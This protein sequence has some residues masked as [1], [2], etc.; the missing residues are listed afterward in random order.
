MKKK[1]LLRVFSFL[2]AGALFLETPAQAFAARMP[3]TIE[4]AAEEDSAAQTEDNDEETPE[5]PESPTEGETPADSETP[6]TPEEPENPTDPEKPETPEEPENPTDPEKP[7]TPEEPE[8]PTDPEKP[9]EPENPTDPEKPETPEEPENPTDPEKP[10]TPEEPENPTDPEKPED[11]TNPTDPENPENPADIEIPDPGVLTEETE[12]P[13]LGEATTAK[14]PLTIE[15]AIYGTEPQNILSDA[16]AEGYKEVLNALSGVMGKDDL[17]AVDLSAY[18]IN[19]TQLQRLLNYL[20]KKNG[21]SLTGLLPEVTYQTDDNGYVHNVWFT[22]AETSISIQV[23]SRSDTSI[24]LRL[25]GLVPN[26]DK[27]TLLRRSESETGVKPVSS[28]QSNTLF[29]DQGTK[30]IHD[31]TDILYAYRGGRICAYTNLVTSEFALAV[32]GGLTVTLDN[33]ASATLKWT[34]PNGVQNYTIYR[35]GASVATLGGDASGWND[36][37]VSSGKNHTY[38]VAAYTSVGSRTCQS[39]ASVTLKWDNGLSKPSVSA[40]SSA[41]DRVTLS[42]GGVSKAAGYLIYQKSGSSFKNL[43]DTSATSYTITGLNA[44]S[45]YQYVVMPYRVSGG[46]KVYGKAS[47]TVSARPKLEKVTLSAKAESYSKITLSW[48]ERGGASGYNIYR[49]TGSES[50]KLVKKVTP[51]STTS[52]T[53][54]KLTLNKKYYYKIV[55][56]VTADGASYEGN[57]SDA[58]SAKPVLQKGKI[59]SV[60]SVNY[61]TLKITWKKVT[62]AQGYELY[63][64]TSSKKGFKRIKTITSGSKVTFTDKDKK[65][66]TAYYYKVKAY[67]KVN[68]KKVY[69][70]YSPV[71]KGKTA[72]NQV[73]SLKVKA[74]DYKTLR[75]TWK[76]VDKSEKYQI[77][78]ATS[79]NGTYKKLATTEETEYE[80]DKATCGQTYYFKVRALR[81]KNGYGTYSAIVSE[82]TTI[83]KP[84]IKIAKIEYDRIT[85]EWEEVDGAQ[86]YEIF[87]STSKDGTYKSL[88]TT[89]SNSFTHKELELEKT[90]YY[91]AK[92]IRQ[93]YTSPFS[94]VKSAKTTLGKLTGLKVTKYY[95]DSLK[96]TWDEVNGATSYQVYRSTA[97]DD[98]EEYKR[99]ASVTTNSYIDSNVSSNKTYYYKVCGVRGTAKTEM[100]G[101][102]SVST[103]SDTERRGIDV[104]SYQG[105]I[106]WKKVA[107]DGIKFAMIRIVTGS[108][109]STTRDER[110]VDNYDGA[111]NNG[112][113]VGV[114][115]Y[116]YATSRTKARE[117][118]E[119]V[120]KA[121]N[122]RKLDYP[123]VMDM[124][125]NSILS[126]TDSNSRRSEII[127]AFKEV[128]EDAGYKFALYANNTWLEQH[129]DMNALKDVD[130]W[131]ARWRDYNLGHGYTG[132]GNVVMWQYTSKGSVSGISGNVDLNVSYK[133]F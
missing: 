103:S 96:I 21:A 95:D 26:A 57:E 1:F 37:N 25:S 8:N 13:A 120:I 48:N 62:G 71:V 66:G 45:S 80:Y 16:E 36:K 102:V 112:I 72:L 74:I 83:G 42:W 99:I 40:S 106:D 56:F 64:S 109:S 29:T 68:G 41:G 6:E 17:H 50:Y 129:L 35:D 118:A 90:Y 22:Y 30:D 114:Y 88:G 122:G 124:E 44:A 23:E 133:D 75:L 61:N 2:I 15:A 113:K 98:E 125:D 59:S 4:S 46:E 9:E 110:F 119:N 47:D 53:D 49:K 107:D 127:L 65:L 58:V 123:I 20:V 130:I 18:K 55:P 116:S 28:V 34:K 7:E 19:T 115:R 108:S 76:K 43:K 10:E 63:R 104:S 51:G 67:R 3:D 93:K 126:G 24:A 12:D 131:I 32:P 85:L 27:Y 89:K 54:S 73:K 69:G 101:P 82:K 52:Y 5:E 105:T 39:E 84:A 11:P 86:K 79:E 81:G 100:A 38:K 70:A 14:T 33:P 60:K 111:R 78:Y 97:K 92:A 77:Y 91:K 132:K 31:Y 117:E 128:V 94:G 121:L 87:G